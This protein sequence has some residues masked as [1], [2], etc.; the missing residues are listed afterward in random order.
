MTE[1]IAPS[2][3]TDGHVV[4]EIIWNG[5]IVDN[6][7]AL[8]ERLYTHYP[9]AIVQ[10]TTTETILLTKTIPGSAFGPNGF[11][12]VDVGAIIRNNSGSTRYPSVRLKLGSSTV[13]NISPPIASGSNRTSFSAR[14][15]VQNANDEALQIATSEMLYLVSPGTEGSQNGL[16]TTGCWHDSTVDTSA[17]LDISL[18]VLLDAAHT[19]YIF[20]MLC[21][22]VVGPIYQE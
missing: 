11:L 20:E 7:N 19:S 1:F 2:Y 16:T 4:D 21:A 10:N 18:A 8:N 15:R 17:A 6:L 22:T 14:F 3:L 5:V 9:Y 13:A 12:M